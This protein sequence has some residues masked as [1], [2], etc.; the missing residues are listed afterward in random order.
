MSTLSP[1][2]RQTPDKP[3]P[4][5]LAPSIYLSSSA[6]VGSVSYLNAKPLTRAIGSPIS[7]L[8]PSRLA[9]DLR[10]GHLNVGLVPLMEIL[11]APAGMYRIVNGV[12]IGAERDVYSVYLNYTGALGKIQTVALDPASKTSVELARLVLEKFHRLKPRYVSPDEPAD[13]QLL[14]GDP[15]I[16]HRQAHPEQNYLDLGEAWRE[17]TQLPFVFAVW[18]LRLPL[19]QSIWTA[20]Q[21]RQAKRIGVSNINLIAR[22]AFERGYLAGHLCYDLG[23]PQKQAIAKFA[24]LLVELGRLPSPPKLNFV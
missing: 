21:L 20:R 12:A 6:R 22:N 19:W 11:E 18:A 23:E 13:A 5:Q 3:E 14:I 24:T 2:H 16:I 7:M 8:E 1:L 4:E 15:A 17:Q 10:A 9:A